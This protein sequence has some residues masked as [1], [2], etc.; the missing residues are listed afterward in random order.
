MVSLPPDGVLVA[1]DTWKGLA[2]SAVAPSLAKEGMT[3]AQASR[4]H[5]WSL[6]TTTNAS[7]GNSRLFIFVRSIDPERPRDGWYPNDLALLDGSRQRI[8][9]FSNDVTADADARCFAFTADLEPGYYILRRGGTQ[10]RQQGV[11]LCSGWET[12]VLIGVDQRSSLRQMTLGMAPYGTGFRADD[13]WFDAAAALFDS[14]LRGTKTVVMS[15]HVRDLLQRELQNPWLGIVAGYALLNIT[16][17]AADEATRQDASARL[18]ELLPKLDPV[19]SHPDVRALR[20]ERRTTDEPFTYPPL[21]RIGLE[22]VRRQAAW[23]ANVA[24]LGSLTERVLAAAIG[25]SPWTAWRHLPGDDADRLDGLGQAPS[26]PTQIFSAL[27]SIYSTLLEH[28]ESGKGAESLQEALARNALVAEARDILRR[29]SL[30]SLPAAIKINTKRIIE[31]ALESTP[32]GDAA[33]LTGVSIG[34]VEK[35]LSELANAFKEATSGPG[36]SIVKRGDLAQGLQQIIDRNIAT[37]VRDRQVPAS[38][39]QDAAERDSTSPSDLSDRLADV[40]CRLESECNRLTVAA[41]TMPADALTQR[42]RETAERLRTLSQSVLEHARFIAIVHD[43]TM[44]YGNTAFKALL[45]TPGQTDVSAKDLAD[46]E[47][48]WCNALWEL[49]GD[50]DHVSDPLNLR[51]WSWRV[52]RMVVQDANDPDVGA[53]MHVLTVE[54]AM[55]AREAPLGETEATLATVTL[56]SSLLA[57]STGDDRATYLD[58]LAALVQTVDTSV[59]SLAGESVPAAAA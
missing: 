54:G 18:A 39:A 8:A 25:N 22:R 7:S 32:T 35:G 31:A 20:I 37:V 26:L 47:R 45:R 11:F 34:R 53:R 28:F 29:T 40:A 6:A 58:T 1:A 42:V 24:P 46:N 17:E 13:E 59:S 56:Y 14:L 30:D 16:K 2:P 9:D 49:P 12:H 55:P 33:A 52:T 10:L 44:L 21:L 36:R 15:Q 57:Y 5:E 23:H 41:D 27:R 43:R 19:M 3:T 38:A 50:Q 51:A 48:A 4:A